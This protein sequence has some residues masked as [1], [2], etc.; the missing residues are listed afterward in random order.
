[1]YKY[2]LATLTVLSKETPAP[3]YNLTLKITDP[4][5]IGATDFS[6]VDS[7]VLNIIIICT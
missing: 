7:V 4:T 2:V 6:E 1:M 3:L 5:I